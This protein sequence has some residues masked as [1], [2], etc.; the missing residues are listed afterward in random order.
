MSLYQRSRLADQILD[1]KWPD[2]LLVGEQML[3]FLSEAG[4]FPTEAIEAGTMSNFEQKA[5][6]A[7]ALVEWA[8]ACEKEYEE[9]CQRQKAKELAAKANQAVPK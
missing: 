3:S 8:E 4:L 9:A 5:L 6:A 7:N 2:M 1:L